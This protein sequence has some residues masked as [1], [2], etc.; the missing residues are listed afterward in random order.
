MERDHRTAHVNDGS[1]A[2]PGLRL[3]RIMH[4]SGVSS[5]SHRS[6]RHPQRSGIG[7]LVDHNGLPDIHRASRELE[8]PARHHSAVGILIV[9]DRRPTDRLLE[10]HEQDPI[11]RNCCLDARQRFAGVEDARIAHGDPSTI[12]H[13]H[14]IEAR[15]EIETAPERRLGGSVSDITGREDQIG[16]NQEAGSYASLGLD[17]ADALATVTGTVEPRRVEKSDTACCGG[18]VGG[19]RGT[20]RSPGS[21]L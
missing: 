20:I 3:G 9:T 12:A 16:G 6:D 8:P 15:C 4:N 2:R 19:D 18:S 11:S 13:D 14:A 10:A 7:M 5:I 17:E 1:A 21:T